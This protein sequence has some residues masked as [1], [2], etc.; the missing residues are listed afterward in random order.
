MRNAIGDSELAGKGRPKLEVDAGAT[1]EAALRASHDRLEA[2][3]QTAFDGYWLVDL[4]GRII[5]V[6][7]AAVAML[8]YTRET[9]LTR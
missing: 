1:A 3:L 6:N 7:D 4:E 2:I 8:G 9:M 5:D